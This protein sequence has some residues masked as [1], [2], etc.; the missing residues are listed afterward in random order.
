MDDNDDINEFYNNSY[1]RSCTD[2]DDAETMMMNDGHGDHND[3]SS[4]DTGCGGS[5]GSV[6]AAAADSDDD[7][8]DGNSNW[9]D[10]AGGNVS[11]DNSDGDSRSTINGE[12]MSVDSLHLLDPTELHTLREFATY[13]CPE[14][15]NDQEHIDIIVSEMIRRHEKF[16]YVTHLDLDSVTLPVYDLPSS[17]ANFCRLEMLTVWSGCVSFPTSMA[18]MTTLEEIV[19]VFFRGQED[20]HGITVLSQDGSPDHNTPFP[21]IKHASFIE[22]GYTRQDWRDGMIIPNPNELF[23]FVEERCPNL[24]AINVI[25]AP[26][27]VTPFIEHLKDSIIAGGG[28]AEEE[29]G[30]QYP[31]STASTG[32]NTSLPRTISIL[33]SQ[34]EENHLETL[35]CDVIIKVRLP[36]R[37]RLNLRSNH[38][39]T[40]RPIA[41]RIKS[42]KSTASTKMKYGCCSELELSLEYNAIWDC[43]MSSSSRHYSQKRAEIDSLVTIVG[44]LG[45]AFL[46]FE[47]CQGCGCELPRR[48]KTALCLSQA[49]SNAFFGQDG[50]DV[51]DG[52][53]PRILHRV[54]SG[55]YHY[56]GDEHLTALHR[57][58]RK[59]PFIVGRT[60]RRLSV[61]QQQEAKHDDGCP[62]KKED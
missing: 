36:E 13:L 43:I 24:E 3:N 29:G 19:Y 37:Y 14:A 16:R 4:A 54:D 9:D 52:D 1:H 58:V 33:E 23:T 28:G 55:M 40:L 59:G 26:S 17:I 8:D 35:L 39:K 62:L 15:I 22:Y 7:D 60:D 34:M 11:E 57:F 10:D 46:D 12:N 45:V 2:G 48:V 21:H 61:Q 51:M 56:S 6:V 47:G 38:I 20:R 27:I 31:N 30:P 44:S 53:W 41:D 25:R 49:R 32:C 5:S 42:M 50:E 18:T